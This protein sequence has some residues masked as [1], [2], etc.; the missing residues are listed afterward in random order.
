[1]KYKVKGIIYNAIY[2]TETKIDARI[3]HIK[4]YWDLPIFVYKIDEV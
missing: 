4:K 1:M 2:F 3:E